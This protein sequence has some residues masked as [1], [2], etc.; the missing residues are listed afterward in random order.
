MSSRK[1]ICRANATGCE[2]VKKF[3]YL[4]KITKTQRMP[5]LLQKIRLPALHR[6]A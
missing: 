3:V 2:V 4:N 6:R 5:A 1:Q